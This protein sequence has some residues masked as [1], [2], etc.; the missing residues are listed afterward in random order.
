MK[1]L[2]LPL[3]ITA[4]RI[5]QIQ[6]QA[7]Y[8]FISGMLIVC[9]LSIA[10]HFDLF[11]SFFLEKDPGAVFFNHIITGIMI[12]VAA[13]LSALFFIRGKKTY[14]Y[15]WIFTWLLF[16][17]QVFFV[18]TGR[19]G[20]FIYLALAL[21]FMIQYFSWKQM[22]SG[23]LVTGTLLTFIFLVSPVLRAGLLE[24]ANNI[25]KYQ[26][27]QK[28][29]PVGLRLQFQQYAYKVFKQHPLLG[30]GLAGL[31]HNFKAYN[32]IPSWDPKLFQP[33]SQYWLVISEQGLVGLLFYI[34]FLWLSFIQ[35]IQSAITR[36]IAYATF[37]MIALVSFSESLLT[38][39]GLGFFCIAMLA[40]CLSA[41]PKKQQPARLTLDTV[42]NDGRLRQAQLKL[43][44]MLQLI[45]AI[46]LKHGLDY[47]LDAGTLLGAVRHKG[48]IPW[49]DDMDI[50]MP[51]ASYEQFIRI[52][53]AELPEHICLQS[54]E[55][56]K[57]YYSLGA[58]LKIRDRTSYY[59]EKH[60]KGNEPYVQGL[61][62][63][64]LVYDKMPI[65][66]TKRNLYKTV[67]KKLLHI[68]STKYTKLPMDHYHHLYKFI[69]YFL[70]KRLLNRSLDKLVKQSNAASSPFLGRGYHCK[71]TTLV[72]TDDI[73]PLKR[74]PFET[75]YFNIPNHADIIL[76][77]EYGDYMILP[78]EHERVLRHCIALTPD[79]PIA[80]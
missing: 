36:P 22:L 26:Q 24:A 44:N 56:D 75:G 32:P 4:F 49:D 52:A 39:S 53:S 62:I 61:F 73:Y 47:W 69:G 1:F 13:Y 27:N 76:T 59:L 68:L 41:R 63:D 67:A 14:R 71:K 20:Y 70:P 9:V 51:R 15:I 23:I 50:A 8:A 10:K 33:H 28:D 38:N 34:G 5:T 78:A 60:E 7:M 42:L 65:N 16:S 19:T 80:V 40:L 55:T 46:C 77:R 74:A 29:T 48:F 58:P 72:S 6:K 35:S 17:Y 66:K 2:Y 79:C 43:F 57:N 21:L 54:S 30:I 25:E 11:L 45:D 18:N 64:V 37:S 31:P 3:I 12:S